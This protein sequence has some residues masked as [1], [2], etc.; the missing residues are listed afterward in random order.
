MNITAIR[1]KF[2]DDYWADEYTFIMGIDQRFTDHFAERFIGLK[3]LETCTGG[4]FTT[5]SL[6]RTA[7][8]VFTVEV[9]QFRQGKAIENI[10][11]AGISS[12]VSFICGSILDP[13]I[14]RKIP[15]IEAAF[16]DPDWAVTGPDHVYRF[17]QSN[18][19]PPAD[20]ALKSMLK[21]TE[22]VAIVLPPFVD[23]KEFN[24]L[25]EHE[26]EKLYLG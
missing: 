11:K 14:L 8:H 24:D 13:E 7:K 19:R 1:E 21:L 6:A 20:I 25:P 5:I 16:I 4:G 2:G 3:V 18:T 26:R 9:D 23:I 17:I 22:N 10:Q 15:K 12:S